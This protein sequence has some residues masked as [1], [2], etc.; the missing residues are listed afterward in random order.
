MLELPPKK[1]VFSL[2]AACER[3]GRSGGLQLGLL[4]DRRAGGGDGVGETSSGKQSWPRCAKSIR[5]LISHYS[6]R[7][8]FC[9]IILTYVYDV[10]G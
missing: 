3:V 10:D 7:S 4:R 9:M 2:P 5:C 8:R 1:Q 6:S